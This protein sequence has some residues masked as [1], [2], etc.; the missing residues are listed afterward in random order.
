MRS[1]GQMCETYEYAS[2]ICE[3]IR[4][5]CARTLCG[6][7]RRAGDRSRGRSYLDDSPR[8]GCLYRSSQRRRYIYVSPK[9]QVAD[10]VPRALS[11][12]DRSSAGQRRSRNCSSTSAR[13][14][15]R[16]NSRSATDSRAV[17]QVAVYQTHHLV[18]DDNMK[19]GAQ[20]DLPLGSLHTLPTNREPLEAGLS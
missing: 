10:T 12:D 20:A 13:L 4:S 17:Y 11:P 19:P 15:R 3:S 1:R 14:C 9:K 5:P 18:S 7:R 16:A 8:C 6:G 2:P